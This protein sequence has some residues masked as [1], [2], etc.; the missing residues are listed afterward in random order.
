MRFLLLPVFLF[1][2]ILT[3]QGNLPR[4]GIIDF[5]AKSVSKTEASAITD[6]FRGEM[7]AGKNFN[8]LDRKN[9]DVILR[10]QE[11]QQTFLSGTTHFCMNMSAGTNFVF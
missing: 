10:E 6:L 5:N 1:S 8:V 2:A 7:I 3:A 4:V 11:F 9:M